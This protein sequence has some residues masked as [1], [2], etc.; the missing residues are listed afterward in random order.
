MD[1]SLEARYGPCSVS[2]THSWPSPT[3]NSGLI[4]AQDST[5]RL[6]LKPEDVD[7][8]TSLLVVL[9]ALKSTCAPPP[10]ASS[11]PKNPRSTSS[12][13][14]LLSKSI[15][16]QSPPLSPIPFPPVPPPRYQPCT[17]PYLSLLL[18][19]HPLTSPYHLP[20]IT[21][22][23]TPDPT[24]YVLLHANVNYR[25]LSPTS[26]PPTA[27]VHSL[28]ALL[29]SLSTRTSLKVLKKLSSFLSAHSTL[30]STSTPCL[31]FMK[32]VLRETIR[33]SG[34]CVATNC[35]LPLSFVL[36]TLHESINDRRSASLCYSRF[37]R[38][39]PS[40]APP[41][42]LGLLRTSRFEA[43]DTERG[44]RAVIDLLKVRREKGRKNLCCCQRHFLLTR[45][46]TPQLNTT[47]V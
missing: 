27:I 26:S 5:K 39:S 1:R 19:L 8:V 43:A 17:P 40:L 46:P 10:T 25:L 20:L 18:H 31:H 29:L 16:H 30:A 28:P 12:I 37:L 2:I 13:L 22:Y 15:D 42:C 34:L 35:T 3:D 24:P 32:D 4:P 38:A 23:S 7:V 14:A 11:S 9:H 47:P 44:L 41:A 33:Y 36:A 45:R 21:L 6:N